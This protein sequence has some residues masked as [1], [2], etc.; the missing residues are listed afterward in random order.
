MYLLE[1]SDGFI[2]LCL[3]IPSVHG[4]QF[5]MSHFR[6]NTLQWFVYIFSYYEMI[7]KK[8]GIPAIDYLII[9]SY[10]FYHDLYAYLPPHFK[11]LDRS[12]PVPSGIMPIAGRRSKMFLKWKRII[13]IP[14]EILRFIICSISAIK[15][16]LTYRNFHHVHNRQY[17][18]NR[19]ISAAYNHPEIWL[20][21]LVFGYFWIDTMIFQCLSRASVEQVV[22]FS[23]L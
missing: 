17:P 19:A 7:N 8:I 14:T 2:N 16:T 15:S 5:R 12:F 22:Y 23:I 4:L 6:K 11:T 18:S 1:F 9:I 3:N 13:W 21:T 10:I 20:S